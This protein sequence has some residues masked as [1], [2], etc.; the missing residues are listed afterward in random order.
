MLQHDQAVRLHAYHLALQATLLEIHDS[1]SLR[2]GIIK[3]EIATEEL[4]LRI[5]R[6]NSRSYAEK[7]EMC[8]KRAEYLNVTDFEEQETEGQRIHH[9][10]HKTL[11]LT[12]NFHFDLRTKF[13]IRKSVETLSEGCSWKYTICEEGG[14]S[15]AGEV[16]TKPLK[17]ARAEV[18]LYGWRKEIFASEITSLEASVTELIGLQ[19]AANLKIGLSESRIA[20]AEMDVEAV[21]L[22][23]N[24]CEQDLQKLN[25]Q[26]SNAT[27][28]LNLVLCLD[29]GS[30]S[31]LASLYGLSSQVDTVEGETPKVTEGAKWLIHSFEISFKVTISLFRSVKSRHEEWMSSLRTSSQV[32]I[33]DI[34]LKALSYGHHEGFEKAGS[35]VAS[36][37]GR[38]RKSAQ[39]LKLHKI[40]MD[41]FRQLRDQYKEVRLATSIEFENLQT[42]I[43]AARD[44]SGHAVSV[45]LNERIRLTKNEMEAHK[46]SFHAIN[47]FSR[48]VGV[49]AAVS[50]HETISDAWMSIYRG[51]KAGA[52]WAT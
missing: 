6:E 25:W 36:Y 50:S 51:K 17:D 19:N 35:Q 8:I 10:I 21:R 41:D 13:P 48:H 4:S 38:G 9:H 12:P 14:T 40:A 26:T 39:T 47:G 28:N 34:I 45:E 18:M 27:Q 3:S 20:S 11:R 43:T 37:L 32:H 5:L 7:L 29:V 46:A 24:T 1:T 30:I 31:G 42:A 33:H 15:F 49:V 52:D 16:K 2:L 23:L 44:I 22:R